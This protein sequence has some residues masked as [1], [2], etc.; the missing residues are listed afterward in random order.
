MGWCEQFWNTKYEHA[1]I[2]HPEG[3]DIKNVR[4]YNGWRKVGKGKAF[5]KRPIYAR[6]ARVMR[7]VAIIPSLLKGQ[8]L[9]TKLAPQLLELRAVIH[10][11]DMRQLLVK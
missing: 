3:S 1:R 5:R 10:V 6:A 2:M 7:T 8:N 11:F 4:V 9:R